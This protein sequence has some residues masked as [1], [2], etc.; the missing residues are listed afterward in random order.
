[1]SYEEVTWQQL[2]EPYVNPNLNDTAMNELDLKNLTGNQ[3]IIEY[4]GV[5]GPFMDEAFC[6]AEKKKTATIQIFIIYTGE[7]YTSIL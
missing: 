5:H 4:G 7:I 3:K 6:F 1:M 2:I